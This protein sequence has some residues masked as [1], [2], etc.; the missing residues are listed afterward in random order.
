MSFH[1]GRETTTEVIARIG[2]SHSLETKLQSVVTPRSMMLNTAGKT[3]GI[4]LLGELFKDLKDCC[5]L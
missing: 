5:L 3:L 2:E 1:V 4:G